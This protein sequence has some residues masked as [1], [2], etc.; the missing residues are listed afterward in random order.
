MSTLTQ[1]HIGHV[2]RCTIVVGLNPTQGSKLSWVYICLALF[3]MYQAHRSLLFRVR[4]GPGKVA[5]IAECENDSI[6]TL[7]SGATIEQASG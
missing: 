1:F 2:Q 6:C 5:I 7:V 3:I 4:V